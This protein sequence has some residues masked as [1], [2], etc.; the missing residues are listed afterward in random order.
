MKPESAKT[1]AGMHD[2]H[3]LIIGSSVTGI[4]AL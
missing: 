4:N 2:V 3:T 1:Y